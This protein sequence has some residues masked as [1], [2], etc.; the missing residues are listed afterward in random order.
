MPP[1]DTEFEIEQ[2][3]AC[4]L[5]PTVPAVAAPIVNPPIVMVNANALMEA[6][7]IVIMTVVEVVLLQVTVMP[8]RLLEPA[9]AVGARDGA[10][11]LKG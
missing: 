9:A 8:V 1:D 7:E 2:K 11:K 10:K 3:F 5:T 4:N 6:P